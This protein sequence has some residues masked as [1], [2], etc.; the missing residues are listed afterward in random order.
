MSRGNSKLNDA[1]RL[2]QLERRLWQAA[3]QLRANSKLRAADYSIPVL[4][5]IFLRYA[6]VRLGLVE[7]RLEAKATARNPVTKA[8]YPGRR[9]HVLAG[10][11]PVR[12]P[13]DAPRGSRVVAICRGPMPRPG[14]GRR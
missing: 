10:G 3:D 8:H 9:S 12:V 13:A 4:G 7:E 14:S 11:G 5:L 1:E 6:D 2:R